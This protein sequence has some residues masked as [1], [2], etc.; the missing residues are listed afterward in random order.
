MI[1][2][3]QLFRALIESAPA[4]THIEDER[5]VRLFVKLL[6][7][8]SRRMLGDQLADQLGYP[9]QRHRVLCNT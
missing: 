3:R 2:P 1:R 9:K 6:Y 5:A 8:M 4:F 7:G